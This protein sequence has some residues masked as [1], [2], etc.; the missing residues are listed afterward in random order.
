[1]EP[2]VGEPYQAAPDTCVIPTY[3]PVPGSG[4][5]PMNAFV[6]DSAEP[7]LVD[8][9]A[10][11]LGDQFMAALESVVRPGD[12]QWIWLTHEDRDHTGSLMRVLEVAPRA[13][14]LTTFM[15]V[16][17][18]L[19]EHP[20]PL[21]RLRL[22]N[23][24]ETVNVGD[25]NLRALRPPL[26]DS[27]ATVGLLDDRTGALFSSD[28]FGAPLP[29]PELATASR[30]DEIPP[31][32]LAPAQLAWASVDSSWVTMA[33]PVVLGRAFD[34]LRRLQP[35]TVL[36]SHLPPIQ[37]CLDRAADTLR[38]APT[39]PPV[40]GVT[41]AELEALLASMEPIKETADVR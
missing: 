30:A 14:V 4:V 26:F 11:A 29:T 33:D 41:Q 27:P 34:E 10:G 37:S 1:M 38:S 12:L 7:V 13:R 21:D 39:T 9:G 6:I 17:R 8:A 32:V 5:I 20:F 16:G 40:P 28:C 2:F 18:M 31:D 19:P 35:R 23:P 22:V 25:R 3:W 24:G 15:A 36:S